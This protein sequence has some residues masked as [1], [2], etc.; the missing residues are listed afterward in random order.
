[1]S[2]ALGEKKKRK[3]SSVTSY[4][5]NVSDD[6]NFQFSGNHKNLDDL[7]FLKEAI[8]VNL[9]IKQ[10]YKCYSQNKPEKRWNIFIYYPCF[11]DEETKAH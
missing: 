2:E 3:T 8:Q 1:M 4:F 10:P 9:I 5:S 6:K 7:Y 11:I